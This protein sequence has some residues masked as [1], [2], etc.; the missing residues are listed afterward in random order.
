MTLRLACSVLLATCALAWAP[1][2]A[3][4]EPAAAAAQAKMGAYTFREYCRSCHG[5]EGKGDGPVGKY[6]SPKPA[7]LTLIR[8]RNRGEFPFDDVYAAIASG[9]AVKG[10]GSSEMPIWGS[11][12]RDVRGGQT[13]EQVAERINQLVHYLV[14][15]QAE[16][17]PKP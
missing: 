6:L 12:F 1:S 10:H 5:S 7:D 4:E 11:A 9:K 3:A 17:K 16:A 8:A 15:I 13:E 2:L 14:S